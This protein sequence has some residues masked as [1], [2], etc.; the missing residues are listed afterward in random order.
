M[1][2]DETI[3]FFNNDRVSKS[4]SQEKSR[5]ILEMLNAD[6]DLI[7]LS[8]EGSDWEEEYAKEQGQENLDISEDEEIDKC[9]NRLLKIYK[10]IDSHFLHTKAVE[11]RGNL[12]KVTNWIDKNLDNDLPKVSTSPNE[13]QNEEESSEEDDQM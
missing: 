8:E 11:F 13:S 9:V 5:S 1:E 4:I 6:Q 3:A 12:D 7:D 2:E 10:K